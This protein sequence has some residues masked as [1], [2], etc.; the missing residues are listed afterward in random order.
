MHAFR[1]NGHSDIIGTCLEGEEG[2]KDEER[3]EIH[4]LCS[5]LDGVIG[6]LHK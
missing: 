6:R 4:S 2:D 5:C 1:Q 3:D